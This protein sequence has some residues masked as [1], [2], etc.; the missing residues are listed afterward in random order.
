MLSYPIASQAYEGHEK[1]VQVIA[2]LSE[3]V[4][5]K[6]F[7]L[8]GE[9]SK[10]SFHLDIVLVRIISHVEDTNSEESGVN[11][12]TIDVDFF[13]D[14]T[15]EDIDQ[16]GVFA[17]VIELFITLMK[18]EISSYSD[19]ENLFKH[20]LVCLSIY[21]T[22]IIFPIRDIKDTAQ[23]VP[24]EIIEECRNKAL[25]NPPNFRRMS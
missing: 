11:R 15:D 16:H 3:K 10:E 12:F 7:D 13:L 2:D 17:P 18:K 4:I 19:S 5:G 22:A 8:K 25:Y 9:Y 23:V 24:D 20:F 14:S 1:Q 6:I 21:K